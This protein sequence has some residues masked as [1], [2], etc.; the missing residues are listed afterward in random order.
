M[1]NQIQTWVNSLKCAYPHLPDRLTIEVEKENIAR[2][3]RWYDELKILREKYDALGDEFLPDHLQ[4]ETGKRQMIPALMSVENMTRDENEARHELFTCL[5]AQMAKIAHKYWRTHSNGAIMEINDVLNYLPI[6]F[7]YVLSSYDPYPQGKNP[8]T[9]HGRNFAHSDKGRVRL[10]TWVHIECRRH[11]NTYLQQNAYMIREGSNYMHRL[12]RQLRQLQEEKLNETG[13]EATTTELVDG[14][15][16]THYGSLVKTSTL[17]GHVKTLT[18]PTSILSFDAPVSHTGGSDSEA[19]IG[20][21]IEDKGQH[22]TSTESLYDPSEELFE[23][24]EDKHLA[25][26][27]EKLCYGSAVLSLKERYAIT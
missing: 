3:Q 9:N 15:K 27:A 23:S 8:K 1:Q 25:A 11:I 16:D 5:S 13:Y 4:G 21:Y 2:L 17:T 24:I 7:L 26:A 20:D 22:Q 6:V 12:R 19:T 10:I 14:L 18:T